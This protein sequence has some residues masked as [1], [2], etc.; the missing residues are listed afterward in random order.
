MEAFEREVSFGFGMVFDARVGICW[1]IM[2][3][4]R[5]QEGSKKCN[6]M[7]PLQ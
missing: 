2:V 7:S 3:A 1:E 6:R 4:S 5:I